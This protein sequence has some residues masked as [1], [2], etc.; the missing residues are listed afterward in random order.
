MIAPPATLVMQWL[1]KSHWAY[2]NTLNAVAPLLGLT[3]ALTLTGPAYLELGSSWR[4][5]LL[6]YSLIVTIIAILWTLLGRTPNHDLPKPR[7]RISQT[8]MRFAKC[9]G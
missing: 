8:P 4:A 7:L 5:V 9:F 3:A 2:M 1:D 6:V